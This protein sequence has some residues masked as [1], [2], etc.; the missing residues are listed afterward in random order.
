M[1]LAP[2]HPGFEVRVVP[3]YRATKPYVCP[4]CVGEVPERTGHVVAWPVDEP[5]RRR[6]W[7]AH[8]W[9]IAVRRGRV[10]G[11]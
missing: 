3:A 2:D 5:D 7:H 10:D 6:H 11:I 8:C 4:E 1:T 9:R